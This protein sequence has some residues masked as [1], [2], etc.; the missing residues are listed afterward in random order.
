MLNAEGQEKRADL[1]V[2]FDWGVLVIDY[3]SGEIAEENIEQMKSY[4][5][6]VKES[7]EFKDNVCGLLVYLDKRKFIPVN[8]D[9]VYEASD[10]CPKMPL[11]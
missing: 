7:G 4:L 11:V 3:K 5:E 2:P 10:S 1:L 6:C 9:K 8:L